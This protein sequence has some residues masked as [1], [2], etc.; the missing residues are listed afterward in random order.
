MLTAL[1]ILC[2][3]QFAAIVRLAWFAWR[4]WNGKREVGNTC[5]FLWEQNKHLRGELD[6]QDKV[7]IERAEAQHKRML[8]QA[9]WN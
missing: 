1:A 5:H 3:I 2:L 6:L 4:Q 9:E 8:K 7:F